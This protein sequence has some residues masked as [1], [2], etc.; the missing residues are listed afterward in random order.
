MAHRPNCRTSSAENAVWRAT[1]P[2]LML[3]GGLLPI[4]PTG[5]SGVP[6]GLASQLGGLKSLFDAG[7]CAVM[8]NVGPLVQ[9]MTLAQWNDGSPTVPVPPQ[10]ASHSD[11]QNVWQTGVPDKP[12][13]TGWLGRMGDVLTASNTGDLSMCI[14]TGGDNNM[15]VG[16]LT[17]PYQITPNGAVRMQG[18]GGFHNATPEAAAALRNLL[19]QQR[20]HQLENQY[21]TVAKRSI[22]AEQQV[23]SALALSTMN[24]VFPDTQIGRQLRMAARL[25]A[26]RSTLGQ[27]RQVFYVASGG[28][29]FHGTLVA[30]QSAKLV[31]LSA[32]LSAFYQATVDLQVENS[33]TA[34][35][36]SDF[37][38]ALQSN[39]DGTDHGWGGH[40]FVVGGA[41]QGKRIYGQVPDAALGTSTDIGQG[42]LLPTTSVDAYAGTLARWFGVSDNDLTIAVPNVRRFMA[43]GTDLGFLG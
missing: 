27:R 26:A 11:Q 16:E 37:G 43:A 31:E 10:I 4:S 28:W 39:G 6:Q 25:I 19:T 14:S 5:Y 22:D 40:H 3:P 32:G 12:S 34:F 21:T 8:A 42:R 35:T 23:T 7:R 41:V 18:L 36:A 2:E 30:D 13:L 24:T 9:P 33:V 17:L 20:S 1:R 29:D 38:R 15:Q